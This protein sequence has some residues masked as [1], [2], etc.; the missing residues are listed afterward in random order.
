MTN[1][2][3][4]REIKE[5]VGI[6][7]GVVGG[8]QTPEEAE[9]VIANKYADYVIIGRAG[10]ADPFWVKKAYECRSDDIIPCIRCG[11]CDKKCSVQLRVDQED[12]IPE[13]LRQD[14]NPKKVVIVGGGPAGMKAAITAKEKGC[15]V[16]LYEKSEQL[17]GML[18]VTEYD[19][20]K[21]DLHNYKNY[22][23]HQVEKQGVEVHFNYD[24]DV[25]KIRKENPDQ[26]VLAMGGLPNI[27]QIEGINE[28]YVLD[29]I[30][31]YTHLDNIGKKVCMLGGGLV[32]CEL[33]LYL[34]KRNHD[35]VIVSRSNHLYPEIG[36]VTK[37]P[38]LKLHKMQ[39]VKILMNKQCRLIEN[40][41]LYF[42]TG[43]IEE[44]DSVIYATGF[45]SNDGDILKYYGICAQTDV[46][47]NLR[48]PGN[49]RNTV[50]DGYFIVAGL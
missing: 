47:G 2:E 6:P 12:W 15:D 49:I 17:G 13:K 50:E 37:G 45:H 31:A 30:E 18:K 14:E 43:E 46:I 11:K 28:N 44:A 8:I 29:C 7:V 25:E 35:V 20:E 19:E 9:Y 16:I 33:A 42:D 40:H 26:L 1:I 34:A 10:I 32:A 22:L 23:I 21:Q 27:P 36:W 4:S 3:Y 39:N 24:G 5:L 38:S 41:R 48:K